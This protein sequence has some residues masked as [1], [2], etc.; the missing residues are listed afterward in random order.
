V[1]SRRICQDF[2]TLSDAWQGGH[3]MPLVSMATTAE[4]IRVLSYPKI[5]AQRRV[6]NAHSRA[7]RQVIGQQL[8]LLVIAR[9][10][11]MPRSF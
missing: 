2:C 9:N 5:Q 1:R 10:A 6:G 11:R 4:L 3:C 7:P 8:L